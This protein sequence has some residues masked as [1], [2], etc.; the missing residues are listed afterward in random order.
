MKNV[1]RLTES[2]LHRIVRNSVKKMINELEG[3]KYSEY[4]SRGFDRDGF[5]KNGYDE[6]GYDRDGWNRNDVH[7]NGYNREQYANMQNSHKAAKDILIEP[8]IQLKENIKNY[9]NTLRNLNKTNKYVDLNDYIYSQ[10]AEHQDVV[11]ECQQRN[12][13]QQRF[14]QII[15]ETINS[16]I[17]RECNNPYLDGIEYL[18]HATP[19]CYVSS[20]R[21]YGLGC[22]LPK[23]RF[24][25]YEG[26]PYENITKGCFLATDEY[27]AESYVENSEAFEELADMYE[28]R[29]DKELEIVV[30]RIK[31]DDLD[32]NL[33]SI[34]TNQIT[35]DDTDPT[36]FYDGVIPYNQ[37]ER[38]RLY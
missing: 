25:N 22:K 10:D 27:V 14:S 4:D 6:D 5:D 15:L 24:W 17:S 33:L 26:T 28:E 2:D 1:I 18:Y 30:F 19:S 20:I 21:K 23:T 37:L 13:I 12:A 34:D 8:S 29:Y 9:L 35:D 16:F 7:I 36:F 3:P 38:I 32:Q 31:V 11:K